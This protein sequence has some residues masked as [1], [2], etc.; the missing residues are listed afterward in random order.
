MSNRRVFIHWP[1]IVN[2]V[3]FCA[4]IF[5]IFLPIREYFNLRALDAELK[6]LNDEV[7]Y[8]GIVDFS[9]AYIKAQKSEHANEFLW[10]V[11]V[12]AN[13]SLIEH[14]EAQES[15]KQF[16]FPPLSFASLVQQGSSLPQRKTA[17][18][19]VDPYETEWSANLELPGGFRH[20]RGIYSVHNGS[21]LTPEDLEMLEAYQN[22]TQSTI[23]L[24]AG[25]TVP[26]F[27]WKLPRI[28]SSDPSNQQSAEKLLQV[29]LT[30][31]ANN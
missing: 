16:T 10:S 17:R 21:R 23:E 12:P 3:L 9:K 25:E 13:C 20:Q 11:Y 1:Q 8:Y 7:A 27:S 2:A 28:K 24:S 31:H 29:D 19:R 6:L 22:G 14:C 4:A 26:L 5:A 15:G 18:I 30:L